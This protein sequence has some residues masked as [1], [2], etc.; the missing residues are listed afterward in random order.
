MLHRSR[1]IRAPIPSRETMPLPTPPSKLGNLLSPDEYK[2]KAHPARPARKQAHEGEQAE[3]PE[4]GRA[5]VAVPMTDAA[6]AAPA[7]RPGRA[8][9]ARR[10]DTPAPGDPPRA[11]KTK[12]TAALLQ[13]VPAMPVSEDE[14]V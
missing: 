14:E 11:R 4:Y 13:P 3:S 10:P 12:Q 8:P 6:S 5:S 2:A 7:P 9:P 1:T